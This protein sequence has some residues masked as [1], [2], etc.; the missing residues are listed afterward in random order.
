[1]HE[2]DASSYVRCAILNCPRL[3]DTRR[4]IVKTKLGLQTSVGRVPVFMHQYTYKIGNNNNNKLKI[5]IN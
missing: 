4:E 5:E 1:M 3:I 2:D